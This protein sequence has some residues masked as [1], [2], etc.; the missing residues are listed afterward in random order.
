MKM[1]FSFMYFFDLIPACK[2]GTCPLLPRGSSWELE[3]EGSE[4]LALCAVLVELSVRV[5]AFL[6]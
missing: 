3:V 4:I 1:T 5:P 6:G 2:Q